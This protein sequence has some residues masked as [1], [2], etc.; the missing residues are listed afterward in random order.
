MVLK[1]IR[2]VSAL[3][4]CR[5]SMLLAESVLIFYKDKYLLK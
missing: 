2:D 1:A 5:K 3:M 4:D